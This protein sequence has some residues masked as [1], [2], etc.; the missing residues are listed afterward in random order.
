MNILRCLA[1]LGIFT[2]GYCYEVYKSYIPNTIRRAIVSIIIWMIFWALLD[3]S[4]K[5]TK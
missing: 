2:Y 1:G 5:N 4:D 3:L